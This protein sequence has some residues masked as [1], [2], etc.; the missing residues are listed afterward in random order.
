MV[1]LHVSLKP[2]MNQRNWEESKSKKKKKK[3]RGR[4]KVSEPEQEKRTKEEMIKERKREGSFTKEK[5]TRKDT[6]WRKPL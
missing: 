3:R 2:R 4:I 5:H 1:P 6:G